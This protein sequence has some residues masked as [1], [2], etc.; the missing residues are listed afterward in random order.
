LPFFG[1]GDFV[2]TEEQAIYSQI[3]AVF[4]SFDIGVFIEAVLWW[5]Y[6]TT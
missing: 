1:I 4:E 6:D 5:D 3:N 2:D